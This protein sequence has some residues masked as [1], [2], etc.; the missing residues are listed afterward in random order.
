VLVRIAPPGTV[1]PD[2]GVPTEVVLP[3]TLAQAK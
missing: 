2:K 3:K 1:F